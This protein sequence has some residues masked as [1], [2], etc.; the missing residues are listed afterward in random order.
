MMLDMTY[1]ERRAFSKTECA[2]IRAKVKDLAKRHQ[3]DTW[4]LAE[5]LYKIRHGVDKDTGEVLWRSWGFASFRHYCEAESPVSRTQSYRLAEIWERTQVQVKSEKRRALAL[6]TTPGKLAPVSSLVDESNVETWCKFVQSRRH[7]E[8]RGARAVAL[9]VPALRSDPEKALSRFNRKTFQ[10]SPGSK[11]IALSVTPKSQVAI[12]LATEIIRR[13]L[14]N[15]RLSPQQ[16]V[17]KALEQFI[18]LVKTGR[19][20]AG[21]DLPPIEISKA[22][23]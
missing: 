14:K 9:R 13:T 19:G 15:P 5:C 6:A 20:G 12:D 3:Q 1:K 4:E 17:V 11:T 22:A 10:A 16:C 18:R 23:P 7:T 21:Y 8:V 2:Q